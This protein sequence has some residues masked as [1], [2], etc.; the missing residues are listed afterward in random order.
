MLDP[1]LFTPLR[2]QLRGPLLLPS[3]DGYDTARQ[4][5]NAMIDRRPAAI[6]RCAGAADVLACVRFAREHD[7]RV[8]VRGGGHNVAGNAVCDD[9]LMI[10]LSPMK[11]IRVDPTRRTARAQPGLTLG[12]FDR[13]TQAF[14]LATTLGAVSMT[15]IAGLTLGGGIGW[16]MG[17]HGLACDN[18]FS[19]DVATADGR[20]LTASAGENPDLYWALRGG[21]GNFG[22]VTSFEYRLHPLG[23]ILG[24]LL[25]FDAAKSEETLHTFREFCRRAPDEMGTGAGFGT[26]PDGAKAVLVP[27]C[28]AGTPAKGEVLVQ[29]LRSLGVA[30][31][32]VKP[33]SYVEMQSCLDVD[34]PPRHYHYWK[35]A[36]LKEL[37]DDAIRVLTQFAAALPTPLSMIFLDYVHGVAARVTPEATAFPHRGEGFSLLAITSWA[38]PRDNE[39]NIRW[40]RDFWAAIEPF[41]SSRVYVNYLGEGE[42]DER[43]RTAYGPNYQRLVALKKKYDP[44]NFFRLNQNIAPARAAAG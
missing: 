21:G 9:G 44:D 31:D 2:E 5:F 37:S 41:T 29:P 7:L 12:E 8:S 34:F 40:T 13:E 33:M 17:K 14:G 35:S 22:V 43:V 1:A 39:K 32:L 11:G 4:I 6:A 26:L 3:E 15:G 20:L 10:D 16:L 42:G 30:A 24:G 38:E 23:T 18:V 27:I 28:Y 36:F 19:Y 25:V